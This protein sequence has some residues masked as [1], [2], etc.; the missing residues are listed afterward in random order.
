[1]QAPGNTFGTP[2]IIVVKNVRL[3]CLVDCMC[4]MYIH[5]TMTFMFVSC[6]LALGDVIIASYCGVMCDSGREAKQCD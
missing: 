4:S 5:V 6:Y 3:N 1:M 2:F